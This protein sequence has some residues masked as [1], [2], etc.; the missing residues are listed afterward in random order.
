MAVITVIAS[1]DMSRVF[2]RG[3]RAVMAGTTGTQHLGVIDYVGR[4]PDDII[5]AI[6][7]NIGGLDVRWIFARGTVAVVTRGAAADDTG[8]IEIRR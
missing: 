3:N 2:P 4:C 7:T 1:R 6:F 5:V 8:V